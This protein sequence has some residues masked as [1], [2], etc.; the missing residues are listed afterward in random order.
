M[1][2]PYVQ[3]IYGGDGIIGMDGTENQMAGNGSTNAISAV[4]TSRISYHNDIRVLLRMERRADKASF[5]LPVL[6]LSHLIYILPGLL[7]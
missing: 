1:V 3:S 2:F 7:L 4:S 5:D 6:D